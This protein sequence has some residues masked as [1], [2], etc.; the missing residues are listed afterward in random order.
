MGLKIIRI[1]DLCGSEHKQI[2]QYRTLC[3]YPENFIC[4]DC[5]LKANKLVDLA[6]KN[7][8][9]NGISC[10]SQIFNSII[11]SE[12]EEAKRIYQHD[13]DKISSYPKI[14]QWFYDNFGCRTHLIKNCKNELCQ[15]LKKYNDSKL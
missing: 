10:V 14:Q 11:R 13:G 7:S 12:I 6:I 2:N 1:C 9:G 15:S 4:S 5:I 3:E 8:N